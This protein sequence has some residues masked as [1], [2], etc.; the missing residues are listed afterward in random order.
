MNSRPYRHLWAREEPC[1]LPDVGGQVWAVFALHLEAERSTFEGTVLDNDE[2]S[3]TCNR[4]P[5]VR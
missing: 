2:E 1:K 3:H 5:S 4:S